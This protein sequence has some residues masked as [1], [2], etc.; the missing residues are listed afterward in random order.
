MVE[1]ENSW[2]RKTRVTA[3]FDQEADVLYVTLGDVVPSEG[4]GF[5]DGLELD[6]AL[7]DGAACAVTIIGYRLYGWP[8][9]LSSLADLIADHFH[10]NQT[11]I[12]RAILRSSTAPSHLG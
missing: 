2:I 1:T 11:E 4:V 7:S 3:D 9:R 10:A 6:Y 5:E 12:T 8:E